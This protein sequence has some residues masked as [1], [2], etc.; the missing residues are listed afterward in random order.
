MG[1]KPKS[2]AEMDADGAKTDPILVATA[3]KKHRF[4]LFSAREPAPEDAADGLGGG[5]DVLNERPTAEVGPLRGA[6][7][8]A[9]AH[10][11]GWPALSACFSSRLSSQMQSQAVQQSTVLGKDAVLRTSL[12]DVH[13]KLF[14]DQCPKTVE[15]FTVP[16]HA[17]WQQRKR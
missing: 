8:P 9:H 3:F 2:R 15:N 10:S 6:W 1:N 7:V 11:C 16:P 13:L 5:R 4:Y 14:G 17:R 12:G